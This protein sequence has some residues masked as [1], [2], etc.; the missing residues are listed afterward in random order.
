MGSESK[1]RIYIHKLLIENV[2]WM[3]KE[4]E[5]EMDKISC[6]FTNSI[7]LIISNVR[8]KGEVCTEFYFK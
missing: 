6:I 7:K 4:K 8:R 2:E 1:I 5:K 3:G